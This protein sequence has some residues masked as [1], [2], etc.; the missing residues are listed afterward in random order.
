MKISL[1]DAEVAR[2]LGTLPSD[3]VFKLINSIAERDSK[4]LLDDLNQIGQLS[5]DYFRLM[6]L[7]SETLQLLSFAKVSEEVFEELEFKKRR[8][9]CTASKALRRRPTT[10]LSNRFNS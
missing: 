7:V 9:S 4:S 1:I 6:D 8:G 5:V 10:S 2:M 3:N